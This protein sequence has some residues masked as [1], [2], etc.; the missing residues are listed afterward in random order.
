MLN[1]LNVATFLE[2]PKNCKFELHFVK[3]FRFASHSD[4]AVLLCPPF[5]NSCQSLIKDPDRFSVR[6]VKSMDFSPRW[7]STNFILPS[8]FSTFSMLLM[9]ISVWKMPKLQEKKILQFLL[10][11]H[12]NSP[13]NNLSFHIHGAF[14]SWYKDCITPSVFCQRGPLLD[15]SNG[16]CL[17]VDWNGIRSSMW[18]PKC[19]I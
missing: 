17:L 5:V 19:P 10:R 18:T 7:R 6:S 4:D 12:L 1:H 13:F 3:H 11:Y 2:H 16:S 14:A 9:R 15:Q 8:R